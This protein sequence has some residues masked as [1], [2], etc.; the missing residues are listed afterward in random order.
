MSNLPNEL[1]YLINREAEN[2]QVIDQLIKDA[3]EE[4]L[5]DLLHAAVQEL[6]IDTAKKI[7]ARQPDVMKLLT[8]KGFS[9][10]PTPVHFYLC[11]DFDYMFMDDEDD[12]AEK[13]LQMLQLLLQHNADPNWQGKHRGPLDAAI[14][15]NHQPL[16]TA[17]LAAG[18]DLNKTKKGSALNV[19]IVSIDDAD[20]RKE[21]L[22]FLLKAG[23]D[24]NGSA[25]HR[26]LL[27]AAS[28][29]QIDS[30]KL[31]LDAGADLTAVNEAGK[32]MLDLAAE[33]LHQD[34]IEFC[35]AKDWHLNA[36]QKI[37]MEYTIA[38]KSLDYRALHD[39][40]TRFPENRL[41]Q[42]HMIS[43]SYAATQIRQHQ[44]AIHWVQKAIDHKVNNL[45]VNRYIAAWVYASKFPEAVAC[46]EQYKDQV[47]L[48]DLDNFAKANL[49]VAAFQ[50][51]NQNLIQTILDSIHACDSTAQGAGLLYFNAACVCS[52]QYQLD[53]AFRFVVAARL[54]NHKTASIDVDS[55]LDAL[56]DSLEFS[57][58][59]D[60]K[61]VGDDYHRVYDNDK[62]IWY[63]R[64][65][66]FEI[67]FAEQFCNP[68]QLESGKSNLDKALAVCYAL[69]DYERRGNNS[70]SRESAAINSMTEDITTAMME[71]LDSDNGDHYQGIRF[72]HNVGNDPLS[73][74]W[75]A[76]GVLDD[77]EQDNL[78]IK[79]T[80]YFWCDDTMYKALVTNIKSITAELFREREFFIQL[81]RSS[82]ED[83]S[84]QLGSQ[85]D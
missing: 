58:L 24:V 23:A 65:Q 16:I 73:C 33:Y 74:Q 35:A 75:W 59:Q 84:I 40:S 36:E 43:F 22:Q 11:D 76:Q 66:L 45:A 46:F 42:S 26:P 49:L 55:D 17:L 30:I 78:K 12:F 20:K 69:R 15:N 83:E 21:M 62:E 31:L 79:F 44:D 41:E 80:S 51:H 32:N 60:W 14:Q 50:T 37:L 57:I 68:I 29:N 48:E 63:F 47:K 67:D 2:E 70:I 13:R 34:I 52:L 10:I 71:L 6:S 28:K 85:S 72:E 81:G 9:K 39:I 56:R 1:S 7:L 3:P 25:E 54:N 82:D 64:D 61:K 77:G 53:Q 27:T 19:A 8:V 18:A 5:G 4:I 38:G